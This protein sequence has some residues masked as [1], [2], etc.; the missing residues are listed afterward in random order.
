MKKKN[1]PDSD[2][3]FDLFNDEGNG[4]VALFFPAVP[5]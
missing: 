2:D 5:A 1:L 3:P 4:I